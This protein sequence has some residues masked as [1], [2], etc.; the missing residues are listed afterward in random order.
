MSHHKN[1]QGDEP[2]SVLARFYD[3]LMKVVDYEGWLDYLEKLLKHYRLVPRTILDLACGTGNMAIPLAQKGYKV[4][5][6][7]RSRDML[8][9]AEKKKTDKSNPVF[10]CQDMRQLA[11]AERVDLVVSF[12]DSVNYIKSFD[13]LIITFK[14]VEKVLHPG[15]Y[16]I[17]DFNTAHRIK[18]IKEGIHIYEGNNYTCFWR[19]RI[20]REKCYWWAEL[21]IFLREGREN[22]RRYREV[23]L[24][25]GYSAG[26]MARAVMAGGLKKIGSLEAYT[27]EKG[28]DNCDRLF[29]IC[30]KV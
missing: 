3:D 24:E 12:Y 26:E 28:W 16:F 23:H 22:Y 2:Y 20:D 21:T 4:Y 13:E 7:D 8:E 11:L 18:S 5:G 1:Y 9:M 30:Q 17:F 6:V 15:G 29:F 19:D 14:N 10:I 27:F 25:R